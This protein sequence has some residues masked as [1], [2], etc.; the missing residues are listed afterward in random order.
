MRTGLEVGDRGMVGSLQKIAPRDQVKP[1]AWI[2]GTKPWPQSGRSQAHSRQRC[3]RLILLGHYRIEVS[4][5]RFQRRA[6]LLDLVSRS[7]SH[8]TQDWHRR[9]PTLDRVLKQKGGY[10]CRKRKPPAVSGDTQYNT[11]EGKC[12]CIRLNGP[13][14]IPFLTEFS[15]PTRNSIRMHCEMA[16]SFPNIA[17][18]LLIYFFARVSRDAIERAGHQCSPSR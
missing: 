3:A 12:R 9:T 7:E 16:H 10:E 13:L 15:E 18:D 6:F 8:A 1:Q 11:G 17:L 4:A 14:D 5:Q 2:N